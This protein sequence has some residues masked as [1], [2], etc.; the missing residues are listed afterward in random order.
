M[1]TYREYGDM[2]NIL[3]HICNTEAC[4][5]IP[6]YRTEKSRLT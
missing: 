2:V 5:P 4:R 1:C 6:L 3:V